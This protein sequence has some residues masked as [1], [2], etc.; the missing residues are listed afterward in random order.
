MDI[1][2]PVVA[3]WP[4]SPDGSSVQ[5]YIDRGYITGIINVGSLLVWLWTLERRSKKRAKLG[6]PTADGETADGSHTR[7]GA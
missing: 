3:D 6:F 4:M 1:S 2:N 7:Q 5:L